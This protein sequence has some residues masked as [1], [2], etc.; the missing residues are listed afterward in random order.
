LRTGVDGNEQGKRVGCVMI[1]PWPRPIQ[2]L[3]PRSSASPG[4]RVPL[5]HASPSARLWPRLC[6]A[7]PP[8]KLAPPPLKSFCLQIQWQ[9]VDTVGDQSSY[10]TAITTHL[11][12]TIPIIRDNLS[13]SRKY[14]TQFCIKF[15]NSFIPKFIQHIYKCKPINTEGAEQLLLDTHMLKTILL[16]LPSISSQINRQAP[17]SYTKVVTKGMTKAEMILKVVMTPV[18]PSKAFIEQYRKLLPECQLNDF[19]KIL[20]MK[21]V[22]R[23]E[24]AV[25]VDV[26]KAYKA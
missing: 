8:T 18:D 11:K 4:A 26:F 15:A 9:N 17:A 7:P 16:N 12:T 24:Q 6:E 21:S 22:K 13:H 3:F 19:Y 2:G 14:F 23:Q 25:L 10:I 1:L 20:D 5:G